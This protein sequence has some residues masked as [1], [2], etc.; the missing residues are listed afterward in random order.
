M[1]RVYGQEPCALCRI[2]FTYSSS[3]SFV[4]DGAVAEKAQAAA[5]GNMRETVFGWFWHWQYGSWRCKA[6]AS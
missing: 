4:V 5:T 1:E 2:H 6:A 3:S